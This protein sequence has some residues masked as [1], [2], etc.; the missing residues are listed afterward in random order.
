MS[1]KRKERVVRK[2]LLWPKTLE[3]ITKWPFQFVGIV[4]EGTIPI[5]TPHHN[6]LV[7][8]D[9]RFTENPPSIFDYIKEN[10]P[11]FTG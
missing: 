1:P 2:F 4:Q 11:S 10:F 9:K 3:G 6:R 8:K 7:W 5:R